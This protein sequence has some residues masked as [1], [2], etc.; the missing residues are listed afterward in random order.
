MIRR[1]ARGE[2][3]TDPSNASRTMLYDIRAGAWD[4]ELLELFGVPER[5]LPTLAPSSGEIGIT[6][7]NALGG[8]AVPLAGVASKGRFTQFEPNREILTILLVLRAAN[9]DEFCTAG[10]PVRRF[11][12]G[13]S[14]ARTVV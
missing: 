2:P 8:H 1:H 6:R 13:R 12:C 7:G 4:P 10:F 11:R 14:I 9:A 5:A 3:A